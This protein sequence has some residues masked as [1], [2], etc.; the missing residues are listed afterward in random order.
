MINRVKNTLIILSSIFLLSGCS[1]VGNKS[2]SMTIAYGITTV[3]S[4]ILLCMCC[5]ILEKK[6]LWMILLFSSIVIVNIGYFALA[7]SRNLEEALLANR[8]SY[9][10]SVF[11]PMAMFMIIINSC[12]INYKKIFPIILVIISIVVF[13]IAASPGYLDIYYKNVMFRKINGVTVLDKVYGPWHSMYLYYLVTYFSLMVLMLIWVY[14]KKKIRNT[15]YSVIL[16]GAVLINIGVWLFEQMVDVNYEFLSVS[17]IISEFFLLCIYVMDSRMQK[18]EKE[19]QIM[20]EKRE[21]AIS[22]IDSEDDKKYEDSDGDKDKEKHIEELCKGMREGIKKLTP[23]EKRIFDMYIADATPA[24]IIEELYITNNTLKF[25]NKNI[26]A[27]LG[28][29]SRKEL[30]EIGKL[31]MEK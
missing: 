5:Y 4:V 6:E 11:L 14:T 25:H 31:I 21:N 15:V 20:L 3:L 9:L 22:K 13:L 1:N 23:A 19:L 28:I 16:A 7:I 18:Q 17:Y 30:V 26:Y 10:G 29:K 8:I 24:K 2:A 27:K 12:R